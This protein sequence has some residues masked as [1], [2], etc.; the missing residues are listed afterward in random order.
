[1]SSPAP[2]PSPLASPR[3]IIS[4]TASMRRPGIEQAI[5]RDGDVAEFPGHPGRALDDLAGLDDPA[6]EAGAHDRRHRAAPPGLRAE[7]HVVRV[8]A[9]EFPSLL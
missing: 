7:P 3:R 2:A 4:R 9:A 5:E 6:A 8:S 1:M